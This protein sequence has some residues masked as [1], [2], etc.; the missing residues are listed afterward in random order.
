[1]VSF[2]GTDDGTYGIPASKVI[3]SVSNNVTI[4][5]VISPL[6]KLSKKV[7]DFSSQSN[8]RVRIHHGKNMATIMKQCQLYVGCVGS[9]I[10]EVAAAG[11][12]MIGIEMSS[13][14]K[15]NGTALRNMGLPVMESLNAS[16]LKLEVSK[17]LNASGMH[18]K[19][20]A[21]IELI[22]NL[23]AKRASDKILSKATIMTT[24]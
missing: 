3:L 17:H 21:L 20:K 1:M 8:K 24:Q 13:N 4:E 7:V 22:D 12:P 6:V 2:G 23:G 16:L 19:N 11:I 5:L 18:S 15:M 10:L 9:T 14:H